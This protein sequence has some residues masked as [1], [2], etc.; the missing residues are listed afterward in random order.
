WSRNHLPFTARFP[1]VAAALTALPVD[2][3][4]IDGEL[5]A[6]DGNRTSF[7]LLQRTQTG[8]RPEF[9]V[10]DLLH[11]LGHDTTVL[12]LSDR[13]RLLVQAL[14]G[15]GG[16]VHVVATVEGNPQVLLEQ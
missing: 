16:A 8:S 7:A 5:V 4:T 11:L 2:N 1:D 6:F 15:V 13:R 14:E 12:P 3:F 9:H 10:F